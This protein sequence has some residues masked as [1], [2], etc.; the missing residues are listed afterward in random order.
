MKAVQLDQFGGPEHLH[1]A[2]VDSPVPGAGQVRIRVR[3]AGVNPI[4]AKI[5]S[6]VLQQVFP[7]ELPAVLGLE[8]AGT[9]DA[10]GADVTAVSVG[11]DVL[12]FADGAGYAEHAL[13]TTV[14]PK[15]AAL[16]WA[17]AAAVPVA[18]ETA[19]RVLRQLE[20]TAGDTLLVHGASGAVGSMAVQLAVARG[21]TVIGTASEANRAF[22]EGLGATALVYGEGLVDRVRAAAPQGVDAVLD[23][24]GRGALPD[25][26]ELRG[27]TS[28]IVTTADPAAYGLGVVFSDTAEPDAA[29]LAEVAAQVAEGTLR[30]ADPRT[31][32]L[33]EAP[34]AHAE[35]GSGRG[36]GKIVLL[37]GGGA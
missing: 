31:Y 2:D 22:V 4:D 21:A 1:L 34:A 7:T 15:P 11:D 37:V 5:R 33:T 13:A 29:Q 6:G 23:T 9:V 32:D 36:R 24:A 14:A 30:L 27:G 17:R 12:G 3:A 16:D 20:V 18:A 35:L 25:S 26:V 10:V 8:V 19:L 28:R